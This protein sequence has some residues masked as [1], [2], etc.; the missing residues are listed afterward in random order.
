MASKK[1]ESRLLVTL[2]EKSRLLSTHSCRSNRDE[3]KAAFEHRMAQVRREVARR[4]RAAISLSPIAASE[5]FASSEDTS[6]DGSV[7]EK[8][9]VWHGECV[10]NPLCN[11]CILTFSMEHRIA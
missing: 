5:V 8:L 6:A 2:K 10:R 9:R 7:S 3:S 11:S 4:I 1:M